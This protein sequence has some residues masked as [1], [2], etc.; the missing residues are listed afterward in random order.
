MIIDYREQNN[1][2]PESESDKR[3]GPLLRVVLVFSAVGLG[4]AV[5]AVPLMQGVLESYSRFGSSGIDRILTGGTEQTTRYT[6]RKSVLNPYTEKI[7][8]IGTQRL[9]EE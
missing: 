7:C 4:A 1:R 8:G 3:V 9:C 2:T 5:L 6:I